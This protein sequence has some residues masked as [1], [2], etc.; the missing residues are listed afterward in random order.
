M[1]FQ[2]G[3][4]F[5]DGREIRDGETAAILA[6]LEVV[7]YAAPSS[8]RAPGVFLALADFEDT[9]PAGAITFDGRLDNRDDLLLA[10]HETVRREASDTALALAAYER[11]GADGFAGLIGDWSLVIWDARR[12]A[13]VLASDFAGVRPLYYSASAEGMFWSTRLRPLVEWVGADEIDDEYAAGFLLHGACPHRTPYRGVFSVPPGHFLTASRN[14]VEIHPFW[15]PPIGNTIRYRRESDY[16]ENLRDLFRD[17]VKSRLRTKAP[18]LSELSG[19]LDSSSIACMATHLMR[20]ESVDATR[21]VTLTF[22]RRD[23]LDTPFYRAVEAACTTESVHLSTAE[24]FY[25]TKEDVGD[26]LPAFW[27]QLHTAVAQVARRMKART[28]F[29]GSLGDLIMG[30]WWDDSGQI[31]GMLRTGRFRGAAGQSLAWSKALRLPVAWVL[32]RALISPDW[33]SEGPDLSSKEDSIAPAFRARMGLSEK[34]RFL[35]RTWM[36]APPE[37][38]KHF[39]GLAETVELRKLQP[40]EPLAHLSYTH[41]YAHRPLV[42]YLLSIPPEILCG[43]GEPRRLMRR[44]FRPFWPPE[45]RR[46]GSKD[47]FGRVFLDALRPLAVDLLGDVDRLQVVERGYVDPVSLRKRLE[48]LVHS[49]DCNQPQL[50]LIILLELWLRTQAEQTPAHQLEPI[51]VTL[52]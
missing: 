43:P 29:T 21:F 40:P 37:R 42:T 19:G 35:S 14:G 34:H 22:E 11:Q 39:R 41:P 46:R 15:L 49:L 16:E 30:N 12:R 36:D 32:W 44:A 2:A 26:E 38:R 50:R 33:S 48:R 45:L 10:H 6:S 23:S 8:W 3:V 13:V 18:V 20:N 47:S 1:S 52:A 5:A 31:A 7:D 4:F 28:V 9:T 24:H 27:D 17:A 51:G 25:L